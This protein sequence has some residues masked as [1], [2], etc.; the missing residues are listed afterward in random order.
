MSKSM[1]NLAAT[2]F[3]AAGIASCAGVAAAMPVADGL[4]LKNAAPMTVESVQWRGRGR[5]WG[6][7]IAG[8]AAGAILGGALLAP[9]YYAPRSYYYGG[10]PYYA[11]S[12]YYADPGPYYSDPGPYSADPGP[13]S[14]DPTGGDPVSYCLQRFRSYD[15]R[16]GTYLGFDGYRHPCP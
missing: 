6:G 13:Y 5:G 7:P 9:R 15:P 16:S 3:M 14:A 8:F 1:R 2:A 11:P 10:G 12:P 4:A